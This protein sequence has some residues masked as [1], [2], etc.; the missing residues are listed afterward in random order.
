MQRVSSLDAALLYAETPEMSLH[1]MGVVVLE[2]PA[3]SSPPAFPLMREVFEARIHRVPELRRRFVEG[4]L[5]LGDPHWIEDPEFDLANHLFRVELPPPRGPRELADF[6]GAYASRTLDRSKPLWE[7]VLIERLER[8]NIAVVA[9]VHHAVMDGARLVALLEHMFDAAPARGARAPS[10]ATPWVPDAMPS[11]AWL[12]ADTARALAAR[13]FRAIDALAHVAGTVL[14]RDPSPRET[15]PAGAGAARLFEAPA[16]PFNGALTAHRAVALADVRF[17]DV[18]AIKRAFGTTVN[19]VVLAACCGALRSWLAA[20]GGLPEKSLVANVPVTV[21]VAA[22][23]AAGNR[24][25]MILVH[26]PVS[27]ADP[28]ERLMAIHAETCRAKEKHGRAGGD[29]LRQ[30]T[31]VVTNL[32]APWLL[33]HVVQL[34]SRIHLADWL[35]FFWNLVISNLPG[36]SRPLRLHGAR[37]RR[38]Y[39]LGPVQQGSGLNLTVM[40]TADRL[41]LGAMACQELVPD[42]DEIGRGFVDEVAVLRRL[43]RRRAPSPGRAGPAGIRPRLT[44]RSRARAARARRRDRG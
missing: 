6:V 1:T 18:Q 26:L 37:V 27:T 19:D 28:V 2:P 11:K 24:V 33:T 13:P 16:T 41:C 36:P 40:S 39:P 23:G 4:P 38:V 5:E 21:R 31:D 29:V 14:S 35:P 43:A 44:A 8:R 7:M 34:Y 15:P 42:V 12:M 30:F 20:H 10:P 32:A 22:D 25:S 17:A 3:G 9:K